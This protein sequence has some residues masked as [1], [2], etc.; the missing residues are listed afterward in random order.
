MLFTHSTVTAVF[1]AAIGVHD[2][3]PTPSTEQ[4]GAAIPGAST[5][6]TSPFSNWDGGS[7]AESQVQQ[8]RLKALGKRRKSHKKIALEVVEEADKEGEEGE[9]T[10]CCKLRMECDAGRCGAKMCTHCSR[11]L[12][13]RADLKVPGRYA[14]DLIIS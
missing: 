8:A 11:L 4:G 12:Q 13:Q 9:H 3:P 1:F 2:A 6:M 7:D 10:S 5:A 14:K